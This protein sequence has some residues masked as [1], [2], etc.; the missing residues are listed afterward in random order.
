MIISSHHHFANFFKKEEEKAIQP[1]AYAVSRNLSHGSVCVDLQDKQGTAGIFEGYKKKIIEGDNFSSTVDLLQTGLVAKGGEIEEKD[2]PFVLK[3]DNFYITRYFNYETQIIEGIKGLITEGEGEKAQRLERLKGSREFTKL[4]ESRDQKNGTDWQLVASAMAYLN[5]FTII[6]GGPGTGKTTT[7]AKI[8]SLLYEEN[9]DLNVKLAAPTGKAAMRMKEALAANKQV[10]EDFREQI[11]ALK[12]YTLHRLLEV[13]HQSPYFKRD[14]EN[15]LDADV[16]IVDE[17]SMIDVALFAKFI[18][19]V[20]PRTRLILLGDQN[21]LASVEAGSLLGDLCNTVG[22]KNKFSSA[23]IS[24][25][26]QLFP[27]QILKQNTGKDELLQDQIVK[28]QHSYRF[29]GDSDFGVLSEAVIDNK[30]EKIESFFEEGRPEGEIVVDNQYKESKFESFIQGFEDYIAEDDI[31]KAIEKFNALRILA[32]IRKG[33]NGVEG[34]NTRVEKYLSK[35]RKINPGQVF[36]KNR[37][38]MVTRNHPDLNLFNGDVGLVRKDKVSGKI[39][40]WFLD[41]EKQ[42][43]EEKQEGEVQERK[44]RSFS[45]GLLTDVETVF[46]MTVHKSQGSE[47]NKVLLVM[48]KS[49]DLPLLTRELLYTGITRAKES[50]IIQGTMEVIKK[51]A[52]AR[53]R[54]ASGITNR[55]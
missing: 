2:K 42:L 10:P 12:P 11:G 28:L 1:Y 54:R 3:G 14:L 7:V 4:V 17:A 46:A 9:P 35:K 50:L 15:K 29:K 48:P 40:I 36:Y 27:E 43:E 49:E 13:K 33:K 19:A 51:S 23:T 18:N 52:E 16:I 22:E 21:Q 44:I 41:E 45:P 26:K 20:D 55:I 8:L 37:P 31:A 25:L 32:V 6:T 53:V 47:F 24:S 30:Q 34:L 38:V 5:N 39:R